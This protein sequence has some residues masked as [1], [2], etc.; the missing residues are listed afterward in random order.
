MEKLIAPWNVKPG[1]LYRWC[2]EHTPNMW[3]LSKVS[4]IVK[5][6]NI[7]A[8]GRWHWTIHFFDNGPLL[9]LHGKGRLLPVQKF[10]Q[11]IPNER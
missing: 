3:H 6:R 1:M 2:Y 8:S 7:F 4:H 10:P 11:Y 5:S 9:T